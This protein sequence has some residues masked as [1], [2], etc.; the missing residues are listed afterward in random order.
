[1]LEIDKINTE[2]FSKRNKVAI[3]HHFNPD[4]DAMGSSLAL[5]LYLQKKGLECVVISPNTAPDFLQWM[6]NAQHILN[7]DS[8]PFRVIE[9]LK[10][11]EYLFCL[12]INLLSRT[13][14]LAPQLE[15][16]A[17]TRIMIDHHLFPQ[18]HFFQ[19]G[20]S[21]PQKSSTCEMVYDY[22]VS[23]NDLD[24]I[25]T[26]IATCLY[27][28]TLT[29]T[30]SFRFQCTTASVH[31][32]VAE[33]IKKGANPS[34]ISSH[35]FDNYQENRL[36]FLGYIFTD[37]LQLFEKQHTALIAVKRTE[38][39]Q[40]QINTGDTEGIVNYP[41]S[42]K[43]IIL[44]IFISEREEEIRMSFR[45]KHNFDVNQF[46]RTYFNGGGHF[47]ASGGKSNLSIEETIEKLTFAI[48]ENEQKLKL[49]FQQSI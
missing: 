15:S 36:R 42:L 45:S 20:I 39:N 17:G 49:C 16:F 23:N 21:N 29:D 43:N 19:Y 7:Y 34:Q 38:L 22:I 40:Y 48:Q 14:F 27:A 33:L 46:A 12:D 31:Y 28:G 3:T 24:L 44:S 5:Q 4:A 18:E 37:K 26:D 9:T 10:Q 13:R 47:N 30:G 41:L 6:P 11:S 2:L 1:M 8:T 25:D 32:M 35:I